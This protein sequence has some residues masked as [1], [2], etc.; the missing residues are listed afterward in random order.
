LVALSP[1][2]DVVVFAQSVCDAILLKLHSGNEEG[3]D[4][5][6]PTAGSRGFTLDIPF[7]PLEAKATTRVAATQTDF[8]KVDLSAWSPPSE[9]EEEARAKEVLRQFAAR[10]W[11]HKLAKEAMQW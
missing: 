11:A 8:A 4:K 9:T 5:P 3:P 2:Q 10:W 7:S 1:G 6:E